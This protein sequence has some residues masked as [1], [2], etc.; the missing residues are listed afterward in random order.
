MRVVFQTEDNQS[1]LPWRVQQRR[2]EGRFGFDSK[3]IPSRSTPAASPPMG[4]RH[5][6]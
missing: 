4:L 6:I 1:R 2:W 3:A 5:P